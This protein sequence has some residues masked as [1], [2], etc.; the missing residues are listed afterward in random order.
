VQFEIK[1]WLTTSQEGKAEVIA[2]EEGG[3][4]FKP[5]AL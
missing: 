5:R 2:N 3:K 4:A 1:Q